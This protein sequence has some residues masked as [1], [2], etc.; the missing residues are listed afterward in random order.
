LRSTLQGGGS[1]YGVRWWAALVLAGTLGGATSALDCMGDAVWGRRGDETELALTTARTVLALQFRSTSLKGW[2][3]SR[4]TLMV[5]FTQ[6]RCG[7]GYLLAGYAVGFDEK[8]R[9]R[10]AL[11]PRPSVR[12]VCSEAGAGWWRVELPASIAQRLVDEPNGAILLA[13]PSGRG[14]VVHSRETFAFAPRLLVEGIAP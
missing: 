11:A 14:P 6:G 1:V 3:A 9:S 12:A 8:A 10:H 13:S 7:E 5:H 4:A 2:R